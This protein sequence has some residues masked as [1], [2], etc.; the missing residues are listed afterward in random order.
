MDCTRF[1]V[2]DAHGYIIVIHS[3]WKTHIIWLAIFSNVFW[4]V[5]TLSKLAVIEMIKK[6]FDFVSALSL[7]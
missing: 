7:H 5:Q 2:I 3:V 6:L 1:T 4:F